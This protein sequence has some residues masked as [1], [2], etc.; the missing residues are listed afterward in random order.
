MFTK[1][2]IHLYSGAAAV[3]RCNIQILGKAPKD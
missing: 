1:T 3:W 2:S